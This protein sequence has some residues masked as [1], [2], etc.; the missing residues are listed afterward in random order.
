MN[1]TIERMIQV[2]PQIQEEDKEEDEEFV[3]PAS[4]CMHL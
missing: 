4:V 3:Q 2:S 1:P